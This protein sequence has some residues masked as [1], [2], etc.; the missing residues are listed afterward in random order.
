MNDPYVYHLE[1]VFV[2]VSC[3]VGCVLVGVEREWLA[4]VLVGVLVACVSVSV[5]V[6]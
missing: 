5:Y 1:S 6:Y 2:D 4:Y 3:M